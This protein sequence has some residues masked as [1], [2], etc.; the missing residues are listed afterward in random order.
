MGIGLSD[1]FLQ[2]FMTGS[3]ENRKK[4]TGTRR[5]VLNIKVKIRICFCDLKTMFKAGRLAQVTAEIRKY[6]LH[7]LGVRESRWIGVRNFKNIN[8][9]YVPVEKKP[10]IKNE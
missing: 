9:F 8:S 7:T 4:T 5:I 1:S 6:K 2:T 3:G 10:N